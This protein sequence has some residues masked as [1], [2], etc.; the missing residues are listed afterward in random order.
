[1]FYKRA[2][3]PDERAPERVH[4]HLVGVT[5]VYPGLRLFCC[6]RRSGKVKPVMTAPRFFFHDDLG[7]RLLKATT[8]LRIDVLKDCD[9][10]VHVS[11][12]ACGT[13]TPCKRLDDIDNGEMLTADDAERHQARALELAGKLV[14]SFASA[15]GGA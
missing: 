8:H 6:A 10:D 9:G 7:D 4:S 2:A 3:S 15:K 13:L 14:A 1:M 12:E 11:F 5:T